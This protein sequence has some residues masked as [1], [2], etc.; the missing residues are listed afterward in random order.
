[1]KK[2]IITIAL[3]LSVCVPVL[4]QQNNGN[5][6]DRIELCKENYA[7]LFGGEALNGQGN[8]PEM[9]DILQKYIFGEV[10]NTGN[11]D[12]R[13][14]ELITCVTLTVMQQ[15]P[16]LKAHAAATLNVGVTPVELR[17]AVYLCAFN[18]GFPKTLNALNTLNTVFVE[19]GITLPLESQATVTE[20]D[21][22]EKGAA[23]RIPLYGDRIKEV[24]KDLPAGMGDNVAGFLNDVYYGEIR[25]RNGLDARTRELLTYCVMTTL[26]AEDQLKSHIRANLKLGN[27]RE[28]LTAAVIQCMPYIGFPAALKALN[29]IKE[30][31]EE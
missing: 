13:T 27:T 26:G 29:V 23:L 31:K 15:L 8:D 10:F 4:A 20:A 30:A 7:R 25:T 12:I 9:M 28:T 3:A 24:L 6:M 2:Q 22:S 19:R 5:E 11:L 16:Q 1:M 18:I 17:E 14:R 21:R